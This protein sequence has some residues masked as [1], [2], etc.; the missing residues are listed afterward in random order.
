MPPLVH[1]DVVSQLT[2]VFIFILGLSSAC[3]R[4]TGENS[5]TAG[6]FQKLPFDRQSHGV[7][8]TPSR[9]LIPITTKLPEG[10]PIPIRLQTALSSAT[11]RAGDTFEATIDEPLVIDG[12][13]LVA[14]GAAARGR[15]LEAKAGTHSPKH[16]AVQSF[17]PGYLRIVLV[18]LN[19]GNRPI[20]VE[21]SSIFAKGGVRDERNSPNGEGTGDSARVSNRKRARENE[22]EKDK[23]KERDVVFGVD[24]RLDFRL[25]QTVD[26]Q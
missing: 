20:L 13:L 7:G 12:Q 14:S 1:R 15:V 24:R 22:N 2:L 19:V 17:E 18:S 9:A 5:T 25:A 10:T 4:P 3:G 21:T 26:L 8:I 11:A 23:D 16:S 6:D